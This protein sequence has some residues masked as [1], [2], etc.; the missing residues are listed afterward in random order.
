M[1]MMSNKDIL[2]IIAHLC[3]LNK[4]AYESLWKAKLMTVV[5]TEQ[6]DLVLSELS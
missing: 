2:D 5:L 3:L 6:A 1:M 4:P